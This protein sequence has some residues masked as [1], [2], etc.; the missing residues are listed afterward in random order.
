MTRTTTLRRSVPPALAAI[1][2]ALSLTSGTASAA[3]AGSTKVGTYRGPVEY[4]QHGPVQVTIKVRNKRIVGVQA[5]YQPPDARSVFLQERAI[6]IL[7][8]ET[9]RAQSARIDIVSGATETSDGYIA[10]LQATIHTAT[11][12]KALN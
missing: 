2:L 9:L 5:A 6:P 1:P 3:H 7:R 4:L 10:S 8:E 11:A 12:H